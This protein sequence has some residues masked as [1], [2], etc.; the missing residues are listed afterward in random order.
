M[1]KKKA[2][3][4][5]QESIISLYID[6]VL[7]KGQPP[8]SVYEFAKI[9]EFDEAVFYQFFASFQKLEAQFLSNM[10]DY[11]LEVID[12]SADYKAYDAAQK[13]SCF[14]F[15]FFEIATANR[16]FVTYLLKSER[17]PLQNLMKLRVNFLEFTKSILDVPIKIENEKFANLQSKAVNEGAWLQFM[18]IIKF[19]LDDHSANFE[20]TDI[21]IE[22]VVKLSFDLIYNVPL[23]SVLDFG[24]F[25]WKEKVGK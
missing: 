23:D 2:L 5:N 17:L 22:K 19:W 9:N 3:E 20:K 8:H 1:A 24:K 14:Y 7:T 15:T 12:K 25:I 21:Y 10:F 16:S 11:T 13:L 6:Y 4:L 18:S